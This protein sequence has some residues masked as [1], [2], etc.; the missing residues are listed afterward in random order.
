MSTPLVSIVTPSYNQAAFLEQT[1]LSV[2]D[3][4]YSAIEYIVVDGAS[5]DGSP[6]IVQRYAERLGWWVSE[7][8]SGQAEAINKGIKRSQGE[9]I[10]WL[11]SDDLY[12]PGIVSGAVAALQADLRLG[13]VFGDGITIDVERRP[14][15]RLTFGDWGLKELM[16]FR[17]ICQPAVFMRREILEMAGWGPEKSALD[18]SYH[19]MLDHHLWLRMAKT[20]PIRHIPAPWAAARHHP[21]AKNVAQAAGFASETQRLLGWMRL[22]PDLAP[23]IT[24]NRKMVEAGAQRL[25]ARYLLDGGQPGPALQAYGKAFLLDPAYTLKHWHRIIYA[26]LSLVGGKSLGNAYYGLRRRRQPDLKGIPE[27]KIQP[28]SKRTK[29]EG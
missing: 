22:Q 18:P 23:L 7:P 13:M 24:A 2:L 27:L 20:A 6:E 15:N 29:N 8:D 10:A 5:T 9:I 17:I 25:I 1:I 26:L 4:D 16:G 21:A 3:Q 19:F 28:Q 14:L 12:F 11:N